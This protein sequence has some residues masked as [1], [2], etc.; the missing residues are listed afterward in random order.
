MSQLV[1]G[2]GL[3]GKPLAEHLVARGDRVLV[4]TRSGA[5]V[6]GASSVILDASDPIAVTAAAEGADTIFLCPNPPYPKWAAEWPPIYEAAISAATAS[7]AGLVM[8]GNLYGY[9]PADGPM[10]EHSPQLTRER[11]GLVRKAGWERALAAHARGDIRVTEVRPSDYFGPEAQGSSH[12][13][14]GFFRPVLAS[15]TA[16]VVGDPALAH[17]W[18]YLPDIVSTLIAAADYVGE[19]GRAWHV[20]S[21]DP[22]ARTEIVRQINSRWGVTGRVAGLPGWALGGLAVFSPMMRE[23]SASSYQFRMPFVVDSAETERLLAVRATPWDEAL[24]DT[25]EYYVRSAEGASATK[26]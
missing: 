17:S 3:I 24:A 22:L 20:P 8:V 13:G 18:S 26:A 1:V 7:G 11:K 10:T 19:W 25:V 23:I 12:L 21:N 6:A 5:S 16:R 14:G 4:A 2:A 9:G 15:K